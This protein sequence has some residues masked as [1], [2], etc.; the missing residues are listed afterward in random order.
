MSG[1]CCCCIEI[2]KS[3]QSSGVMCLLQAPT[4]TR[5]QAWR[6]AMLCDSFSAD[7][8]GTKTPTTPYLK[9]T[10]GSAALCLPRLLR[11]APVMLR[12]AV[13]RHLGGWCGPKQPRQAHIRGSCSHRWLAAGLVFKPTAGHQQEQQQQWAKQQHATAGWNALAATTQALPYR[14]CAHFAT[15]HNRCN[16]VRRLLMGS[17]HSCSVQKQQQRGKLLPCNAHSRVQHSLLQADPVAGGDQRDPS[18]PQQRSNGCAHDVAVPQHHC[19][20]ASQ[21]DP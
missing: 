19:C 1:L 11:A 12:R 13:L 4:H 21:A 8:T 2:D 18:V 20:P 3:T 7:G 17:V 16:P 9:P 14:M 5:P 6:H 10:A 15:S